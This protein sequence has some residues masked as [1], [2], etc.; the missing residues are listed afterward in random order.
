M[1]TIYNISTTFECE[2]GYSGYPCQD[3]EWSDYRW[4]TLLL[5]IPSIGILST[6]LISKYGYFNLQPAVKRNRKTYL[7]W[8]NLLQLITHSGYILEFL[9]GNIGWTFYGV[10]EFQQ[11]LF[12]TNG[13]IQIANYILTIYV[14]WEIVIS[15]DLEKFSKKEYI[16]VKVK[17]WLIGITIFNYILVIISRIV[18]LSYRKTELSSNLGALADLL[19]GLVVL[20]S[21]ILFIVTGI[22]FLRI[23]YNQKDFNELPQL[24]LAKKST[25]IIMSASILN[26]VLIIY[27]IVVS[28]N[29]SNTM[30]GFYFLRI[31]NVTLAI[32]LYVGTN[33]SLKPQIGSNSSRSTN[34]S[35]NGNNIG[36]GNSGNS[37]SEKNTSKNIPNEMI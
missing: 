35:N 16:I 26:I 5:W 13:S 24:K 15:C 12:L 4:F 11:I 30:L 28:T 8:N 7:Y 21:T 17:W 32:I 2:P 27:L 25:L 37:G 36:I 10:N 33:L 9:I 22:R 34:S 20:I 19:I 3:K 14:W 1:S 29:D 18:Y 6:L 23:L 31:I